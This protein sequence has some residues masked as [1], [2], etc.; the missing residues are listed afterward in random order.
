MNLLGFFKS[1][2]QLLFNTDEAK[3]NKLSTYFTDVQWEF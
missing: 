3:S 1:E 2:F